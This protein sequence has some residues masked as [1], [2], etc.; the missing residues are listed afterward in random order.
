MKIPF[1]PVPVP[2]QFTGLFD[3]EDKSYFMLRRKAL[4]ACSSNGST[5]SQKEAVK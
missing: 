3:G 4:V 1:P 5:I 2:H